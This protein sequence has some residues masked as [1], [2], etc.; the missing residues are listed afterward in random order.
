M[1]ISYNEF[2]EETLHQPIHFAF[3]GGTWWC[4]DYIIEGKLVRY[5]GVK[6]S[7]RVTKNQMLDEE[8]ITRPVGK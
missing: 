4:E 8:N 6:G 1:D 3:S 7:Q 5:A 2:K